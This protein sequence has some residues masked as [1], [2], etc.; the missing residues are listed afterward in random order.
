VAKSSQ[1][2]TSPDVSS[3]SKCRANRRDATV[4]Q[5]PARFFQGFASLEGS[6]AD[7]AE[8]VFCRRKKDF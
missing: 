5:P 2:A 3:E 1:A 6:H 4:F 8:K 7:Q